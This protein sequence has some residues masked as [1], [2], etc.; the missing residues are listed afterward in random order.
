MK[1][2]FFTIVL[3]SFLLSSS[4]GP[5][6]GKQADNSDGT[7]V[8]FIKSEAENKVDVMI[9]DKLFTSFCWFDN[10]TKPVLYPIMSVNL[11][12][13]TRG[14][15]IKPREN[16]RND[17]PHQIGNWLTYGDVNGFDFWGNG[18]QGLGTNNPNGGVIKHLGIESQQ[19]GNGEGVLITTASWISPKN[20]ELLKE[21]TEYHFIDKGNARIIDRIAT[22]TATD[23]VVKFADTKEGMFGIRVARQLELPA[24]EDLQLKEKSG[25]ITT[26][27]ALSNDEV[28][29]N[30]RSSEGIEGEAVWSTRAKW[31][32]LFG[33]LKDEK[34]SLVICDHPGNPSYPTYWHARGY[35][36]FSA[37]PLGVKDFT[38]NKE[39]LNFTLQPGQSVTFRYRLVVNSGEFL[40]EAQINEFTDEFGVKYK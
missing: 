36:L 17:H 33:S 38:V 25:D 12:E 19:D 1:L 23:T 5:K 14:F 21:R 15:P 22:L 40:T 10:M 37:N 39:V 8:T 2:Q 20:K 30:Y 7:K 29:G 11:S 32:H 26:V 28:T 6:S 31:M 34:I 9:G 4:C 3:L 24:K 16:E 35:G 27:K 18:S 13:V